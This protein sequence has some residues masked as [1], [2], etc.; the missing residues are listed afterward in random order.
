MPVVT[1]LTNY[2]DNMCAHGH[3]VL[4]SGN[5]VPPPPTILMGFR[6]IPRLRRSTAPPR[7]PQG[8][9][10]R[11]EVHAD[12]GPGSTCQWIEDDAFNR[13]LQAAIR[14]VTVLD[15]LRARYGSARVY[16]IAWPCGA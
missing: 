14:R 16:I 8:C 4:L 7:L 15:D 1:L 13:R 6:C 3:A 11:L 12:V 9:L 2:I 5:S 10:W